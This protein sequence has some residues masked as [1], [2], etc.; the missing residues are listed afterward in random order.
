MTLKIGRYTVILKPLS[1][2]IKWMKDTDMYGIILWDFY[3][4]RTMFD[5]IQDRKKEIGVD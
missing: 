2:G 1:C 5:D 3:G 4:E